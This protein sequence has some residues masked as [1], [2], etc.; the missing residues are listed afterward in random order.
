MEEEHLTNIFFS[1]SGIIHWMEPHIDSIMVD[2]GF[3]I[4]DICARNN[5]KVIMP[6]FLKKKS[7][8]TKQEAL[9]NRKIAACRV[10]VERAIGRM[11]EFRILKDL[12][13]WNLSGYA[14]VITKV[15]AAMVNLHPALIC[16]SRFP[17]QD[18]QSL[19]TPNSTFD[20]GDSEYEDIEILDVSFQ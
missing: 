17:P 5:V 15:I 14:E 10:N 18:T 8:F 13:P 2:K 3:L 12:L 9:S 6:S 16:E 19:V 11:K 1:E 4:H 20:N 7:R